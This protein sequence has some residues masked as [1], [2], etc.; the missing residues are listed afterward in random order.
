MS[1]KT[2]LWTYCI[3][4]VAFETL[5]FGGIGYAVFWLGYS[6]WWFA[7]AAMC[8]SGCFRPWHWRAIL[9]GEKPKGALI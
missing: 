4:I 7:F 5:I 8:S 3:Y 1:D 2:L 9:T 6:G